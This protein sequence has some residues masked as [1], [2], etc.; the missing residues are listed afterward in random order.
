MSREIIRFESVDIRY[1]HTETS[2]LSGITFAI[3]EHE[4][5]ALIGSNGTGKTTLLLAACGLVEHSGKIVFEDRELN[6]DNLDFIRQRMGFLFSIP[7]DQILFPSVIEDIMFTLLSR[8]VD[9]VE[10]E[11]KSLEILK[12]LGMYNYA[13]TTPYRLS[14]GERLKVALAGILVGEPELLLLDEPSSGLDPLA[15]RRLVDILL[16]CNSAQIVAT[17]DTAFARSLCSRYILLEGGRIISEGSDF[18][19]IDT[20]WESKIS[21]S[22]NTL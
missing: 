22:N 9:R 3:K 14:Y 8:G 18:E 17:H 16:K 10:A 15:K 7:D 6:R 1:H 19:D 4:R 5:V 11:R 21:K 20:Y 13:K 12:S 2:V